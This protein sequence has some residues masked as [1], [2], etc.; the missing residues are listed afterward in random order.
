[1]NNNDISISYN[2]ITT[3]SNNKNEKNL[4]FHFYYY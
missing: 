1:M 3:S 4:A 2:F